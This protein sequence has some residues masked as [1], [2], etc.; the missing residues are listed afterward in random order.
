MRQRYCPRTSAPWC[1]LL[2]TRLKC[3][4][5]PTFSVL[6][7][8]SFHNLS[9]VESL[10]DR[11]F[12][13][14]QCESHDILL[15]CPWHSG[16]F[17]FFNLQSPARGPFRGHPTSTRILDGPST[18]ASISCDWGSTSTFFKFFESQ[19]QET[20]HLSCLPTYSSV[21]LAPQLFCSLSAS[22][23]PSVLTGLKMYPKT[24]KLL[25]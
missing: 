19:S 11:V 25:L 8:V 20:P 23:L 6:F 3:Q 22:V 7:F 18:Y 1:L 15:S 13:I 14:H 2:V 4:A 16:I 24:L 5:V 10:P 9:Y 21:R 12:H 17:P